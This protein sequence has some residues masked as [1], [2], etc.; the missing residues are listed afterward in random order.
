MKWIK[1]LIPY[2]IIIIVVVFIRTFIIT[3]V[4]VNGASMER[5]LYNGEILLLQKVDRNF[6]RFDIVV[7][8]Y[9]K[10][11]LIKRIVGLPGEYIEYKNNKLYINDKIVTEKFND[12]ITGYF[13][14]K[15]KG[16]N[17]IPKGYYFVMGD[18]RT[19]SV[20]SRII[21]LIKKEDIL[22]KTKFALYPLDRFGIID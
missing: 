16:I 10:E 1:E 18:N 3:P 15:S 13:D 22:G 14:L 20:D 11:K 21:G 8:N 5:T 4:R 19:N 9:Q 7:I 6:K 17:V 12:S 2:V